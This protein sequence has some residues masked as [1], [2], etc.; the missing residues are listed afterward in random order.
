M[1]VRDSFQFQRTN[2]SHLFLF[3][4]V[5]L[6]N[7]LFPFEDGYLWAEGLSIDIVLALWFLIWLTFRGYFV[8]GLGR[9]Y[10]DWL[11]KL[12]LL[13]SFFLTGQGWSLV[14]QQAVNHLSERHFWNL[15]PRHLYQIL[16]WDLV[17]EITSSNQFLLDAV[18]LMDCGWIDRI[19]DLFLAF[20]VIRLDIVYWLQDT[21]RP[22]SLHQLFIHLCLLL[23]A[24]HPR[25]LGLLRLQN[26]FLHQFLAHQFIGLLLIWLIVWGTP[27]FIRLLLIHLETDW[28]NYT[29]EKTKFKSN[30]KIMKLTIL[31]FEDLFVLIVVAFYIVLL[32]AGWV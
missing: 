11:T 23:L 21:F 26:T 25:L 2:E 22:P 15:V 16:R 8:S 14:L 12:L 28:L 4:L 29:F 19:W 10:G 18:A 32:Q 13:Y 1:L 5:S 3:L 6:K 31:L 27:A 20:H 7:A 24:L 30:N 9:S 17:L